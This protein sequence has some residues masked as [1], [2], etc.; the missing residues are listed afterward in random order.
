MKKLV[1]VLIAIIVVG[2]LIFSGCN[3][4][5][6]FVE[7][8]Y[9]TKDLVI[10]NVILDVSDREIEVTTSS[11]NQIHINYFESEK[12][13]YDISLTD[14]TLK[15]TIVF[16]K[17]WT[18]FIGTKAEKEYRKI[19]L[20]IPNALLTDLTIKTTNE[21]IEVC[22][23]EVKESILLDSN[24]GNIELDKV[25][26]GKTIN[27]TVKD[28]DIIGSVVGGWDDYTI[29]VSIK[30]GESNLANKDGGEK[31]LSVDCNNRN[32]RIDLIK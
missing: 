6:T 32:I 10:N 11:D 19:K 2:L 28:A 14:G 31:L 29:N 8:T 16:D 12:E 24:G 23:L 9:S 17:K 26:A 13:Y 22:E 30:K 25:F 7:K 4:G 1:T 15:M 27:L 20:E 21:K 18:D 3:N 5:G